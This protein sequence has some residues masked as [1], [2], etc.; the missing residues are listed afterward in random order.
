MTTNE[1][2][3][4]TTDSATINFPST[5]SVPATILLSQLFISLH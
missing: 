4:M 1:A 3:Y 5:I 2:T